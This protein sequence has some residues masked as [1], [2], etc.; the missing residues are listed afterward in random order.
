MPSH[1]S[2]RLAPLI[3]CDYCPLL[4]H[5]DCLDPPLTALPAGKW[6]CPNHVEHLVVRGL[7]S[8]RAPHIRPEAFFSFHLKR[9]SDVQLNQRTLSLSSR[10][11]LFDQFQDRMS[12][13]AVK[14]DF[15]RRVHRQN[16]PNRRSAHPHS[17][18]TIKV[19]WGFKREGVG[20]MLLEGGVSPSENPPPV[21]ASGAGCHQVPVPESSFHA[22]SCRGAPVGT[23]LQRR[24]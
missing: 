12:Q 23:G 10:C 2:C 7:V 5:M 21:V 14:L 8:D 3:Q 19:G 16:A 11:Q 1:R 18:K 4:F 20:A 22:A 24:S 9:L 15:L 17:K 6:M 13:H